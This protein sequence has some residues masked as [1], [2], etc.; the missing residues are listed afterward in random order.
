MLTTL[1]PHP[2]GAKR[3]NGTEAATVKPKQAKTVRAR[4][5]KKPA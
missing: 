3:R 1:L 4:R 2:K 5:V